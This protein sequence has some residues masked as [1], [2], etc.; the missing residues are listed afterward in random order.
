MQIK[1][2]EKEQRPREKA[3][4][5]G[6]DSLSDEELLALILTSGVPGKNVVEVSRQL[7]EKAGGFFGL[8]KCDKK[9]L[10]SFSGVSEVKALEVMALGEISRRAYRELLP[11]LAKPKAEDL[12]KIYAPS[13]ATLSKET[14]ILLLYDKR[15]RFS[16][17]RRLYL[18]TSDSLCVSHLEILKELLR[19][20]AY[21]FYVLHNHPSGDPIP[22]QGEVEDTLRLKEEAEELSLHMLDHVVVAGDRFFSFTGNSLFRKALS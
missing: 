10:S 22:S 21:Y 8:F 6:I 4:S 13:F 17:E 15:G 11:R 5:K 12:F 3:L 18:G 20:D 7:L 9:T 1:E 19:G 14:L 2:I 16:G